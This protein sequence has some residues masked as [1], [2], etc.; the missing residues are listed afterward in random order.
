MKFNDYKYQRPDIDAISKAVGQQLEIFNSASD[1]SIQIDAILKINSIREQFETMAD[2]SYIRYTIDTRDAFYE[3]EN[4]YFDENMPEYEKIVNQYYKAITTSKFDKELRLRF[5]NQL[6]DFAETKLETFSDD[7]LEEMKTDNKLSS[8]YTKLR[9]SCKIDW[10]GEEKNLSQM[11]PYLEAEDR[12]E[13]IEASKAYYGFM[14]DNMDAF[15]DIY[16]EM[17]K[18][19]TS[20][21]KKLGYENFVEL[22]YKKLGRTDYNKDD[23]KKFR[24]GVKKYVVP[25]VTKLKEKQRQRLGVDTLMNYDEKLIFTTG[26]PKPQGDPKWIMDQGIKMYNEMSVE[27]KEFFDFMMENEL[28]DLEAK[29]GKSGGGYCTYMPGFKSP[30]IFSNFNGTLGDV[31]VLTHE[32]GHAFQVYM[33]RDNELIEYYWATLEASEVHS[34][35][36]EFIAYPWM[37]S[38]FGDDLEKY[39][40]A[41]FT[42]SLIFLPYGVLVDEFQHWVYENPEVSKEERRAMWRQLEREYLPHREYDMEFLENG[43]FWFVQGHIFKDP[44]YYVDYTL[45]QVCAYQFWIKCEIDRGK[46]WKDYLRLCKEGGKQPFL[47]LLE[48]ANLENPFNEDVLKDIMEPIEMFIDSIDDQSL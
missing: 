35:S 14:A 15:D 31:D 45:A 7:V 2:L 9:A 26:N 6:F 22:G 12:T 48:L 44:F 46:G 37:E 47:K 41:H 43:G 23:V 32:A 11:I 30:F 33:S 38:F 13:R 36:M 24:E 8:K 10:R 4:D 40:F 19:R 25:Y 29:K 16:D 28:M 1:A 18:V 27:T 21:A 3:G 42:N 5:G 39:F 20:M 17:V 34:M